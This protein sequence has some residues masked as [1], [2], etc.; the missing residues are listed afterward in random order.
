MSLFAHGTGMIFKLTHLFC[1]FFTL[2]VF[3]QTP[4]VSSQTSSLVD[5]SEKMAASWAPEEKRPSE[6]N[7]P[8][9]KSPKTVPSSPLTESG[10][11]KKKP[12]GGVSLFGGIDVVGSKQTKLLDEVDDAGGFLCRESPPPNV[13]K[14][15]KVTRNTFSLF[16]DDEEDESDWNEPKFTPSKPNTKTTVKVCEELFSLTASVWRLL[17][18]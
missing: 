14:E 16:D 11:S 4:A 2:L 13:K 17:C 18:L 5:K 9:T 10:G 7:E 1:S 15:D 12:V 8:T 6:Y 3:V